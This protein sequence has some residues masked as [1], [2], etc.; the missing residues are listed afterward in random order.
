[1]PLP[2]EASG[3]EFSGDGGLPRPT[4]RFANL[5]SNITQVLLGVNKS[6]QAMI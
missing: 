6:H 5:N 3:F 1:M 4:I 2:V